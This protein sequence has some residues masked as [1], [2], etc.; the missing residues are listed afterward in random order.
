MIGICG[1][2]GK[3]GYALYKY[4]NTKEDSVFGTYY[5]HP[6]DGLVY[7]DITKDEFSIFNSCNVVI[8]T[9]ACTDISLCESNSKETKLINVTRTI[10]FINYLNTKNIKSLFLSSILAST[11]CIYGQ[12]KLLVEKHIDLSSYVR[13]KEIK[14]KNIPSFCEEIYKKI[15]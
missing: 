11:Q 2:S 5:K 1:A 3:L 6:K 14:N 7:F 15:S 12:Q 4:L 10:E 9:S 13:L 8:I